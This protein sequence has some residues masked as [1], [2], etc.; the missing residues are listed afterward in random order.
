VKSAW[1]RDGKVDPVMGGPVKSGLEDYAAFYRG[2]LTDDRSLTPLAVAL[3]TIVAIWALVYLVGCI[4]PLAQP[5]G[6]RTA[7][8]WS[9][10]AAGRP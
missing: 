2:Y 7:L 1:R 4:G 10:L 3:A 9:V 5:P 6:G 8:Q